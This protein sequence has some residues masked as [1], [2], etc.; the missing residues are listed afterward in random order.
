VESQSACAQSP[1]LPSAP[2]E[3]DLSK[4]SEFGLKNAFSASFFERSAGTHNFSERVAAWRALFPQG[5]EVVAGGRAKR[6]PRNASPP[7]TFHPGE[8]WQKI[9]SSKLSLAPLPGVLASELAK[10]DK[11]RANPALPRILNV[12]FL[13]ARPSPLPRD[14]L[15]IRPIDAIPALS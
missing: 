10:P 12:A 9:Q 15:V 14:G 2:R 4:I 7:E 3:T 8:G 11:R 5:T 6:H 13:G 1:A